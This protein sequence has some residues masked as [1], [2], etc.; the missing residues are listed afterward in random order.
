LSV[1]ELRHQ[2]LQEAVLPN[3]AAGEERGLLRSDAPGEGRTEAA[4]QHFGENPVIRVQE[5]DGAV[6]PTELQVPRLLDGDDR[7]IEKPGRHAAGA[8][9]GGKEGGEKRPKEVA[10]A[11]V[12][13]HGEAIGTWRTPRRG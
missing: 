11:A 13:L 10:K 9:D 1:E 3:L 5:G 12:E 4:S 2:L 6:I 7:A 8:A